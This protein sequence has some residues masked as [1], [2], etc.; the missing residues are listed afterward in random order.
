[1]SKYR[2][3]LND[4]DLAEFKWWLQKNGW[5]ITGGN[6]YVTAEKNKGKYWVNTLKPYKGTIE[7]MCNPEDVL[8]KFFETFGSKVTINVNG[9]NNMIIEN[10]GEITI[11]L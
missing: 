10:V 8:D 1:M 4:K 3:Y 11:N 9:K 5:E 2:R 6:G 7:V